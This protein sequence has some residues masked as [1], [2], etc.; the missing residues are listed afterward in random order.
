MLFEEERSRA[1]SNPIFGKLPFLAKD[2]TNDRESGAKS[3]PEGSGLGLKKLSFPLHL[4]RV[5]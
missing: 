5:P 2:K 4:R 1:L 3:K